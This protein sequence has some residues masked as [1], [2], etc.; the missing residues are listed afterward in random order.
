[1]K[2]G[3]LVVAGKYIKT[4]F[5]LKFIFNIN[6]VK[7]FKFLQKHFLSNRAAVQLGGTRR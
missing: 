4:F 7:Q 2:T 6:T 1:L 5:L 3:T